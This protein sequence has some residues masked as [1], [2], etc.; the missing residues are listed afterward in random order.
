[1]KC[2]NLQ[3]NLPIYLDGYLDEDE[4][5]VLDAHLA[6]CPVC[7][8]KLADF[9]GLRNNLRVL[10]R[11]EIP[12]NLM[13]SLRMAVA[14]ELEAK[15]NRIFSESFRRWIE[16]SVMP[17]T[18]G[19]AATF[20]FAFLL[21]GAMLSGANPNRE[22]AQVTPQI[23]TTK[24]I[25]QKSSEYTF[26]EDQEMLITQEDFA[27][28]RIDVSG[29]SPSINPTGAI[30]ALTKSLVR[31]KMKDNEVVV[32]ADVFGDGLA[33][34]AEVVESPKDD[35]T[36]ENLKNAFNADFE[37]APFVPAAL[38]NRAS[39]IRVV[40]KIQLVDVKVKKVKSEKVK[41]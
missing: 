32:V 2:E 31:G 3:F 29:E 15:P 5:A 25:F 4:R 8:Q 39:E 11:P 26:P 30:V 14:E 18:V 35:K 16:L 38:D 34:I 20:L 19:V 28:H 36:L 1:M 12:Q 22:T 17:Y 37:N 21:L 41:K 10:A 27:R 9:Q 6:V 24:I 13:N 40:F 7:R 23:E 33:Q